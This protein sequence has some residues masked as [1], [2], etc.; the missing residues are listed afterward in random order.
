MSCLKPLRLQNPL[1]SKN[2]RVNHKYRLSET[3]EVPCGRCLLCHITKQQWLIDAG[4]YELKKNNF[5]S[6]L[7]LTYDDRHLHLVDQPDKTKLATL[8]YKDI[9][10]FIRKI[11]DELDIKFSYIYAGEYGQNPK[12][13]ILP[14]PHFHIALFGVDYL[15]YG[16]KMQEYWYH[17]LC[18]V[19][20][21]ESGCVR[22]IVKYLDKHIDDKTDYERLGI[23]K[24]RCRHS[25]A[26][27][28]GLV[29]DN[30][31]D[32]KQNNY[33]YVSRHNKRLPI[34]SYLMRKIFGKALPKFESIRYQMLHDYA[35]VPKNG[36]YFTLKEIND[37]KKNK[38]KLTYSRLQSKMI[39]NRIA[40]P[41]EEIKND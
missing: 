31:D 11:R 27:G 21:V 20:P 10:K 40:I 6:F 1:Y 14:R 17:G 5:A 34:P 7:T 33:T 15:T 26:F 36:K 9:L 13:G 29:Y 35:L 2:V 30:L 32:V 23:K 24:P 25:N 37:F 12:D 18:D 41:Y 38:I 4:N 22:Y 16:K 39:E 19:K 8:E 28:F 3:I